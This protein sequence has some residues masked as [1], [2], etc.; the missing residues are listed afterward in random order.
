MVGGMKPDASERRVGHPPPI[1]LLTHGWLES[2]VCPV[3][4]WVSLVPAV[5]EKTVVVL[6]RST[7]DLAAVRGPRRH[8][9]KV[10]FEGSWMRRWF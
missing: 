9:A 4:V 6:G 1:A 8:L 5:T 7:G 3:R 2:V 10:A